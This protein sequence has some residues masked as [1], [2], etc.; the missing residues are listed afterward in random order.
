MSSL[1]SAENITVSFLDD[2]NL[3]PSQ[4]SA[5]TE[6]A[7]AGRGF[8]AHH[9]GEPETRRMLFRRGL[10]G[11]HVIVALW[12]GHPAGIATYKHRLKGPMLPVFT[13]FTRTFGSS[14]IR[15]WLVY[16]AA[17]ARMRSRGVYVCGIEVFEKFRR[18]GVG[19]ALIA[20][21]AHVARDLGAPVVELDVRKT[22]QSAQAF[23][24][25]HDFAPPVYPL[26]SLDRLNVKVTRDFQR[27]SLAMEP[28]R[29]D[30]A[31][32]GVRSIR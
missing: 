4:S 30:Q 27:L 31:L 11:R 9:L 2:P 8:L 17:E 6:F 28:H 23:Y 14:A 25:A 12:D 20:K 13:D 7:A 22:N 32:L 18:R 19:S 1:A 5:A 3:T 10:Q 24:R 15:P 16:H 29:I 26:I 21:L